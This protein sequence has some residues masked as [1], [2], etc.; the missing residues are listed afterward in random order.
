M[1]L[2]KDILTFLRLDYRDAL[3]I[4]LYLVVIGISIPKSDEYDNHN[5]Q[6]FIVKKVKNLKISMFQMT[7][8]C[9]STLPNSYLI[10]IGIIIQRIDGSILT[11]SN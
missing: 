10:I 9:V 8:Y 4:T 2:F 7:Y 3:L 11:Y 6:K 1:I 5:I